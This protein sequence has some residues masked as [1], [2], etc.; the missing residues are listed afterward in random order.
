MFKNFLQ[1]FFNIFNKKKPNKTNNRIIIKA[2]KKSIKNLLWSNF[3]SVKDPK[4]ALKIYF[5]QVQLWSQI[6]VIF[7]AKWRRVLNNSI[8]KTS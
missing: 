7:G 1:I 5:L 2:K 6:E 4:K 8:I 3:K